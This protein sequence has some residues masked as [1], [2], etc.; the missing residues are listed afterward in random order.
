[1][2][3][4]TRRRVLKSGAA[5]AGGGM[6][7]ALS[8]DL[9]RGV[10]ELLIMG[11]QAPNLTGTM[12][13]AN[14]AAGAG[15]QEL[16]IQAFPG[17]EPNG[18]QSIVAR[19][20]GS[21]AIL[22][23]VNRRI[24]I[25]RERRIQQTIDLPRAVLPTD[26]EEAGSRLFVLD[27]IGDQVLEV[28]GSTVRSHGLPAAS[29]GRTSGLGQGANGPIEVLEEDASSYS[30]ARG[31]G[32]LAAGFPNRAGGKVNVDY[33]TNSF[34]RHRAKAYLGRPVSAL[35]SSQVG[36]ETAGYLG[37]VTV[38]GFDDAGRTYL[39]SSELIVGATGYEV[40][41]VVRRCEPGGAVTAFARVPVRNRWAN[42][43][44][45]VTIAPTG[46]AFAIFS[47]RTGTLLL[48]LAWQPRLTA[49]AA[50]LVLTAAR[51]FEALAIGE[52]GNIPVCRLAAISMAN[53]YYAH[54]WWCTL[55][56]WNTC[57][58]DGYTSSRPLYIAQG[59]YDTWYGYVPYDWGGW[60]SIAQ[61]DTGIQAGRTAGN[62]NPARV[63]FCT[64]GVDCSGFIQ[65]CWNVGSVKVDDTG[66]LGWCSNMAPMDWQNPPPWMQL[67]DFYRLPGAHARMHDHYQDL[68][69]GP[70]VFES[71]GNPGRVHWTFYSWQSLSAYQWCLG[72]FTC[73]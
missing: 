38:A 10:S 63:L 71:I 72:K 27:G 59:G 30:L 23:T 28:N 47:Q 11:Q 5:L 51:N 33:E 6:L 56:N 69:T 13:V 57:A 21:L 32:A 66:L 43:T 58:E 40:D 46:Q 44:R 7:T 52:Q 4:L 2:G 54:A 26:I 14:F 31:R 65:R 62:T 20:D 18:P 8:P 42:P 61:F 50:P 12:T 48:E 34:L 68:S 36:I 22:D 53:D 9:V 37:S 70:Y 60:D 67:G 64:N 15:P 29:R 49:L 39:L 24:A 17:M 73:V 16:G 41:L 1:M 45:A 3:G 19:R 55:S 35:G 25:V